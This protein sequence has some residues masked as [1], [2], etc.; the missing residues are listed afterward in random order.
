MINTKNKT[1][2]E[3]GVGVEEVYKARSAALRVH[4]GGGT[5]AGRCGEEAKSR[6]PLDAVLRC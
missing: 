3:R 1:H 6:E 5:A 2:A 4:R